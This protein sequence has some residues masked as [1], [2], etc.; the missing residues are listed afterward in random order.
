MALYE[1]KSSYFV[2]PEEDQIVATGKD[3][4][5]M[6]DVE[7]T[8]IFP[9]RRGNTNIGLIEL[10]DF[11]HKRDITPVQLTLLR[12]VA[13][14]ASYSI[15]NA[16]LLQ[17]A[18]EQLVEKTALLNDKEVLLKEVH[19]RVKN[20]LQVI[21]SLLNLQSAKI[22]DPETK[23][24]LRES[25]NRVRTMAL[26]HEK[27]YQSTDLAQ[28]DFASYLRSL[29]NFLSQS[30]RGKSDNVS[31]DVDAQNVMLDI[32]TAIPCGL[33]V[34]E[35]VSNSLKYAFPDN[36]RGQ[37]KLDC[38]HGNN[39][40]YV[41]TV[42]D[43]GVGLPEGFDIAKTPSLGHKLVVSLTNQLNGKLEIVRER[44]TAFRISF[45]RMS[46]AKGQHTNR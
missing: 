16:R 12:T 43:D 2:Y 10:Y 45:E 30:Y 25:Q 7:S 13:D 41:L 32:D 4:S 9:L 22:L 33:I 46:N 44:G 26:I 38:R 31:I 35:L 17:R 18:Q 28:V 5:V 39:G 14:K 6:M 36:R 24:I 23:D 20:N 37:I 40:N 8:I 19:H 15:Q 34:N 27:L 3:L 21:S 11:N 29:V 1:G 42:S